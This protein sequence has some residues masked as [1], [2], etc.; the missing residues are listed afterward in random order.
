MK[1]TKTK[2]YDGCLPSDNKHYKKYKKDYKKRGFDDSV[3]WS[4]DESLI[5]WLTPR[6]TR[7]LEISKQKHDEAKLHKNIKI[8]LKGFNLYLS[9]DFNEFN[10]KHTKQLDKSFKLLAKNYSGLW[11]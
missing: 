3:T 11:W 4:L 6:L 8:I 7:F 9:D 5:K 1:F 10:L 2:Y